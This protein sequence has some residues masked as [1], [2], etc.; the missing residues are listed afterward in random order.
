MSNTSFGN[1]EQ[2]TLALM[3]LGLCMR[4]L[5]VDCESFMVGSSSNRPQQALEGVSWARGRNVT[6]ACMIAG[7]RTNGACCEI[8][9][10]PQRRL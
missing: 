10:W 2:V 5:K 1:M 4:E 8:Y 7:I 6:A 9:H 3:D